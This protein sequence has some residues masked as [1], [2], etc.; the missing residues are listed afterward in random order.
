MPITRHRSPTSSSRTARRSPRSSPCPTSPTRL[1]TSPPPPQKKGPSKGLIIGIVAAVVVVVA[2]VVVLGGKKDDEPTSVAEPT[3]VEESADSSA[4]DSGDDTESTDTDSTDDESADDNSAATALGVVGTDLS[5]VTLADRVTD[6]TS[7]YGFSFCPL[8]SMVEETTDG[9]L[10]YDSADP[11]M[12]AIAFG[13]KNSDGDDAEGWA[14]WFAYQNED[15]QD[16]GLFVAQSDET[17]FTLVGT[18]ADSDGDRLV[19]R[20][21]VNSD[22][23]Q[24]LCIYYKADQEADM[25]PSVAA[26]ADSFEAGTGTGNE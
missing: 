20:G 11:Y 2:L 25:L 4:D 19:V 7:G 23:V 12:V 16:F 8:P 1:A 5:G 14:N 15:Y 17:T 3:T 22:T 26:V 21:L 10:Y 9:R 6:T 18:Q 24:L 13:G